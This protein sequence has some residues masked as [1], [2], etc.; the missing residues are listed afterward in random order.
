M[1]NT[2]VLCLGVACCLSGA[3]LFADDIILP[4]GDPDIY[5]PHL[6]STLVRHEQEERSAD[7]LRKFEH[8]VRSAVHENE[9]DKIAKKIRTKCLAM[10]K[11]DFAIP[12]R[13]KENS[14]LADE[15]Y[16]D[17][18]LTQKT[19]SLNIKKMSVKKAFEL[20]NKISGMAFVVD[21]NVGGVVDEVQV[22][23]VPIA[24]ALQLILN[25]AQPRL[26]LVKTFGVWRVMHHELAKEMLKVHDQRTR[27]LDCLNA[28]YTMNHAKWDDK[29]KTR[30]EKLWDGVVGDQKGK[31][32][33]FI[34][35]DDST[36]KIFFKSC[37]S[38]V[39]DFEKMLQEVDIQAPQ[40]RLDVRVIIADKNF[41]EMLGFQWSGRYDRK[42]VSRRLEFSGVGA[43]QNT[44]GSAT[45]TNPFGAVTDWSLNL[46]PAWKT[47]ATAIKD[48]ANKD[49]MFSLPFIFR[50]ADYSKLLNLTLNA[51]ENRHEIK[52]ILKPSL[53]VNS[54]E[55]AEIL[56]GESMPLQ[57]MVAESVGSNISNVT[58][59]Q[60]KDLGIKVNVKPVV[61]PA[62][63]TVFL[64]IFLENSSLSVPSTAVNWKQDG[65][66]QTL[67]YTIKTSRTKNRVLLRSGQTTLIS[68]LIVN[69]SDT[70][71]NGVPLLQ[72]IPVLGWLFRGSKK[73]VEDKQLLIFITPVVV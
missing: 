59:T 72:D 19:I 24:V 6:N 12:S 37:V 61:S 67:G 34:A 13:E 54:E 50:N 5:L 51:A 38:N 62:S 28:A 11:K 68:G 33:T 64:D 14:M 22:S 32:G 65:K 52:T 4:A 71:K 9:R 43:K 53:L 16:K 49:G 41:E 73:S 25:C 2:H 44:D 7:S 36:K 31:S 57:T 47:G 45:V 20:I 21:P 27:E 55:S 29:F 35:F 10:V 42:M 66:D 3:F 26:G 15:V 39:H 48:F 46:I 58:T 56:V 8:I 18:E 17:P 1:K 60:Y 70:M 69:S 63:D 30:I 23:D 40:V